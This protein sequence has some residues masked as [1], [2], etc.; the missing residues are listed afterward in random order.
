MK[1][2]VSPRLKP[3][4]SKHFVQRLPN[5]SIPVAIS[6]DQFHAYWDKCPMSLKRNSLVFFSKELIDL[7]NKTNSRLLYCDLLS[8]K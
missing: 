5:V 7:V 2:K 8:K 4:L 1:V 6:L 3:L